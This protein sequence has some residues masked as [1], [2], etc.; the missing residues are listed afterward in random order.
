MRGFIERFFRTVNQRFLQYLSG[1][2]F[3][4]IEERGDH[5]AEKRAC[6]SEDQTAVVIALLIADVYHNEPHSG[7]NGRTPLQQWEA[8]MSETP[9]N[10]HWA[11]APPVN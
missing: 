8:D 3:G 11:P 6:L 7:L 9:I 2:T 4:S 10:D 5:E 1:R